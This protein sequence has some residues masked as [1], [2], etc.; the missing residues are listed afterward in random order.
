MGNNYNCSYRH[1][2]SI[3][4]GNRIKGK[5]GAFQEGKTFWLSG[6]NGNANKRKG[7]YNSYI[8]GNIVYVGKDI[9]PKIAVDKA[10]KGVFVANNIF[11]FENDPVMVFGD[12]YKPDIGGGSQIKNVFFE[13]N[14]FK[15][16]HWPNDVLIQ[17]NNSI[18][19]S[20][21]LSFFNKLPYYN[22]R[23]LDLKFANN[24]EQIINMLEKSAV[25]ITTVAFFSNFNKII[26][27]YIKEDSKGLWQ[28][29]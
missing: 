13:N 28:G 21:L 27:D 11:Y 3:N 18:Y 1:N 14:I 10:A 15:K 25:A 9:I 2:V 22:K 8:Y 12:Q 23:N 24:T 5:N 17:P 16:N 26:I 20:S 7:P 29:F 4:D 6:Y 19:E